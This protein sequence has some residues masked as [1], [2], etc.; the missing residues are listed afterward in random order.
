[1][2]RKKFEQV[3]A[4]IP[5]RDR[6]FAEGAGHACG[7][8]GK[9]AMTTGSALNCRRAAGDTLSCAGTF[10]LAGILAQCY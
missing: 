2:R 8:K 3:S 1:M 9:I 10:I 7:I 4:R 5:L 6:V